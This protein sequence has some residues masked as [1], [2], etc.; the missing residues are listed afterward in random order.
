M[1]LEI[2]EESCGRSKK[3][4]E[5]STIFYIREMPYRP[6]YSIQATA[7]SEEA[8]EWMK[9]RILESIPLE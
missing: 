3:G 6:G 5:S 8:A 4:A 7:L 2:F 1:K 9:Q